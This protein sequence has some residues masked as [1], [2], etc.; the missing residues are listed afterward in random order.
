MIRCVW[1]V[2][3]VGIGVRIGITEALNICRG[4]AERLATDGRCVREWDGV[5]FETGVTGT[6][7]G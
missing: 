5:L 1:V 2:R 7:V 3:E 6:S 4:K